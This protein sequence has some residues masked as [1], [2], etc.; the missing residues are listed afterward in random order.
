MFNKYFLELKNR[1]LVTFCSWVFTMCMCYFYK[2][3]L[4][5]LLIKLNIKLYNLH[6]FYF[7]STNISD[8]FSVYLKL[9]YFI[10]NQFA[11]ILAVYHIGSFL[12]PG[13]FKFEYNALKLTFSV[14][15]V[16]FIFSLILLHWF[17]LPF[18]CDFF[19]SFLSDSTINVFFESKLTEYF[20]FYKEIY[21][22]ICCIGQFFA[23]ILV[24]IYFIDKKINFILSSRKF[25]YVSFL[26]LSTLITPPDVISQIIV[27]TYFIIFYELMLV[28]VFL[29]KYI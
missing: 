24:Y 15:G 13:L 22:L 10:S 6:T 27:T 28:G 9:S 12:A 25:V 29:K 16:L 11:I 18:L 26:I 2:N 14:F 1:A 7:I 4:V 3:I 17:V 20:Q 23:L 21:F 19:F 5:F 8:V